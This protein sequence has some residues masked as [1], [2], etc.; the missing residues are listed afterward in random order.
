MIGLWLQKICQSL[1]Q[2]TIII[3]AGQ[4]LKKQAGT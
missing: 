1:G 3:G 2:K 4:S